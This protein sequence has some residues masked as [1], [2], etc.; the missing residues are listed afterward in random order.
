M[1]FETYSFWDGDVVHGVLLVISN[2]ALIPAILYLA[3]KRD[4]I[5]SL[6][7]IGTFVSS[8]M[9]HSCRSGIFC[10]FR[11]ELHKIADYLSVYMSITWMLTM[12]GIRNMTLHVF[13]FFFCYII[14]QF[15]VLGEASQMLLPVV[16]IGLPAVVSLV[17]AHLK[18]KTMFYRKGWSIATFIL[19][20]LA[21][22]FMFV[23]PD[24]HYGW[25]HSIWHVFSM[26]SAWTFA[27]ATTPLP[28][29]RKK[30]NNRI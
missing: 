7:L 9:Y 26:L 6:L 29:R 1:S 27:V 21:G 12:L 25:A 20:G 24:R 11:Y 17:H 5:T 19:A 8:S 18:H 22:I 15:F 3:F 28:E 4:V 30:I 13:A 2:A 10:P 23:M 16:G 14:T